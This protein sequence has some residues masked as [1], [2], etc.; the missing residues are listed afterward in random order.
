MVA[1]PSKFNLLNVKGTDSLKEKG[2]DAGANVTNEAGYADLRDVVNER[3]GINC[4]TKTTKDRFVALI[5]K[6][7]ITKKYMDDN[8]K[9]M[10]LERMI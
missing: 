4:T 3:C 2:V 7:K 1:I 10:G 9:N 6:Y 8:G 5:K